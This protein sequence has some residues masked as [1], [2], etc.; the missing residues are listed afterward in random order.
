MSSKSKLV[1]RKKSDV[2]A[3]QEQVQDNQVTR[4]EK[5]KVDQRRSQ[6]TN[7]QQCIYQRKGGAPIVQQDLQAEQ[8][9]QPN[10]QAKMQDREGNVYLNDK[11]FLV[12]DSG[13]GAQKQNQRAKSTSN[14]G[15]LNNNKKGN[16]PNNH[17]RFDNKPVYK[18]KSNKFRN[19]GQR[20]Q[21][22]IQNPD[23]YYVF[24]VE[25]NDIV[26]DS[27]R[28]EVIINSQASLQ[29]EPDQQISIVPQIVCEDL[30]PFGLKQYDELQ[31]MDSQQSDD[32]STSAQTQS[33]QSN[34]LTIKTEQS[35]IHEQLE[36]F[37]QIVKS[38]FDSNNLN[39]KEDDSASKMSSQLTNFSSETGMSSQYSQNKSEE[40]LDA[41][42]L[43]HKIKAG[44]QNNV[45][46]KAKLSR[47]QL[48][49]Y[50]RID[51]I[52]KSHKS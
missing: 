9:A 42:I 35:K 21:Q 11:A 40:K 1:Y 49:T 7:K 8:K 45:N 19:Q 38:T 47:Y 10:N 25:D 52:S 30:S 37:D 18:P 6:S 43:I 32:R 31:N 51:Q 12:V 22:F 34:S 50:S 44:V 29:N 26:Q 27:D 4:Q 5:R 16:Q 24:S 23:T 15:R 41:Q 48:L 14:N 33:S 28:G 20:D 13:T 36:T 46:Q 3:Y 2:Q 17:Q 39:Y